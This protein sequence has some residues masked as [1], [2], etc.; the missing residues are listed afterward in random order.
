MSIIGISAALRL[1]SLTQEQSTS[2]QTDPSIIVE[3]SVEVRVIDRRSTAAVFFAPLSSE[4]TPWY[5]FKTIGWYEAFGEYDAPMSPLPS[6]I[7]LEDAS[8]NQYGVVM[9]LPVAIFEQSKPY[10]GR[11]TPKLIRFKQMTLV[12][13][14]HPL[15]QGM[16]TA[17]KWTN[18]SFPGISDRIRES[19]GRINYRPSS[20]RMSA[21]TFLAQKG[22]DFVANYL[23]AVN[24]ANNG[25]PAFVM[26]GS[27]YPVGV[28]GAPQ[29]VT[30]MGDGKGVWMINGASIL[31]GRSPTPP[32][33]FKCMS[34]CYSVNHTYEPPDF[35]DGEK[36][37]GKL[38]ARALLAHGMAVSAHKSNYSSLH[39]GVHQSSEADF[40][41][42]AR[43]VQKE[44][45][46]FEGKGT[47]KPSAAPVPAPSN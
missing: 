17:M 45:I 46:L 20:E 8:Y 42:K 1:T 30:I 35:F 43:M 36:G 9:P 25:R 24:Y 5:T 37:P 10:Q 4:I 15:N 16:S 14:I 39:S 26:Q 38:S 28:P 19:V 44:L 12:T 32:P 41:A 31:Q 7:H 40:D 47:P 18:Q 23:T 27:T 3:H 13:R 22:D 2:L 34:L 11:E 21:T 29:A 6:Q 33:S